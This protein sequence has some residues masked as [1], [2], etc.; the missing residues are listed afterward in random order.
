M[1]IVIIVLIHTHIYIYRYTFLWF[2]Y[3]VYMFFGTCIMHTSWILWRSLQF[4]RSEVGPNL[5]PHTDHC[6]EAWCEDRSLAVQGLLNVKSMMWSENGTR[7]AD[8]KR[9]CILPEGNML[10]PL[11]I[12]RCICIKWQWHRHMLREW[13]CLRFWTSHTLRSDWCYDQA[14]TLR[15]QWKSCA[16]PGETLLE[17]S[18]R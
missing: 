18:W 8:D 15:D 9:C 5:G 4:P 10:T 12:R 2:D 17:K 3:D 1:M 11:S 16:S 7:A 14:A 6:S 13:Q